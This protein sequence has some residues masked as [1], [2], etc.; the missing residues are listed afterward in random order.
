M[1]E[2]ERFYSTIV[3]EMPSNVA[4]LVWTKEKHTV[5]QHKETQLVWIWLLNITHIPVNWTKSKNIV[6]P[7]QSATLTTSQDE[8]DAIKE[9]SIWLL[10]FVTV[11]PG[12]RL[13][14]LWVLLQIRD[15]YVWQDKG[16]NHMYFIV[17]A[18]FPVIN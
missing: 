11:L 1:K 3:E 8:E 5:K 13:Q 10:K 4:D 6:D 9:N 2:I 14:S 12:G 16:Y 18:E 17:H 15:T 7:M